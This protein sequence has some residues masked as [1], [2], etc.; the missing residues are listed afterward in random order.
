MISPRAGTP[1]PMP[2]ETIVCAL[3]SRSPVSVKLSVASAVEVTVMPL[4]PA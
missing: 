4:A 3:V 2:T 1:I